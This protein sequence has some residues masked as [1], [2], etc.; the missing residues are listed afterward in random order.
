MRPIKN[1]AKIH[2]LQKSPILNYKN[3][4]NDL[5]FNTISKITYAISIWKIFFYFMA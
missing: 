5:R 1:L 3:L 4:E 2:I